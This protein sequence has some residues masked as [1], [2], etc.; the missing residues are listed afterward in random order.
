MR[1]NFKVLFMK[2]ILFIWVL[3]FTLPLCAQEIAPDKKPKRS[4]RII[5]TSKPI[6]APEEAFIFDG[7]KSHKVLLPSLNLSEVIELPMGEITLGLIPH[8]IND[9]E[10]F[11]AGAPTVKIP[12]SYKDIYLFL[13]VDLKNKILPIKISVVN[14]EKNKL[15]IGHTLWVNMS[16][17][18]IGASLGKEKLVIPAKKF[19]ISPPPLNDSGYFLAQFA[20]QIKGKG[21]FLPIFKKSWWH[22]DTCRHIGFIINSGAKMPEIFTI[23]DRRSKL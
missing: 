6:D 22:D 11:P 23:R 20:Y 17:H 13:S 3:I 15:K 10:L 1:Y 4:C 12:E 9:P 14:I 21:D 19:V 8:E 18:N 5:Y 7:E 16:E 2:S